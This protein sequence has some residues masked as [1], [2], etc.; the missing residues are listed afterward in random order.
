M[1]LIIETA[2]EEMVINY[3]NGDVWIGMQEAD[4]ETIKTILIE[5]VKNGEEEELEK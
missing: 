2:P 4:M 3:P 5:V 1:K